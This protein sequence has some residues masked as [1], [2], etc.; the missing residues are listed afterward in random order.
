MWE[1]TAY[2]APSCYPDHINKS[3]L[4]TSVSAC[5]MDDIAEG[6]ARQRGWVPGRDNE[7]PFSCGKCGEALVT[8]I[9][10]LS[11]SDT[12]L[13]QMQD[14]ARGLM[15]MEGRPELLENGF[16]LICSP[17]V[18]L[19]MGSEAMAGRAAWSSPQSFFYYIHLETHFASTALLTKYEVLTL[20]INL[21]MLYSYVE[22]RPASCMPCATSPEAQN[23][24]SHCSTS[25]IPALTPEWHV[26][27]PH[28]TDVAP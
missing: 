22:D 19:L 27:P 24:L 2:F 23:S 3:G 10:N 21:N 8:S 9:S 26:S 4:W 15:Q 28:Y 25:A 13:Q 1:K 6:P 20:Q 17:S 16:T 14:P 18:C 11:K 7:P 12:N 5:I